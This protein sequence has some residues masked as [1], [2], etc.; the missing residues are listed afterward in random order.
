MLCKDIVTHARARARIYTIEHKEYIFIKRK[1]PRLILIL[2][3]LFSSR[4]ICMALI[5]IEYR[6]DSGFMFPAT[7]RGFP[8]PSLP[9]GEQYANKKLLVL[10]DD[11]C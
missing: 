2:S 11:L 1:T 10:L 5:L 3:L 6:L 7:F 9:D 8:S 4:K